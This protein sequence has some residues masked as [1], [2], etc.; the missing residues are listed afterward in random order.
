MQNQIPVITG[1]RTFDIEVVGESFYTNHF[2]TICGPR[3][4]G[5]E[6]LEKTAQLTL[7]TNNKFDKLAVKVTIDGLA[8]GHLPRDIARE[9]R[10]AIKS[11][12]LS[13]FHVFECTAWITCG[14][15]KG[16]GNQGHYCLKV[17]L[18]Q[19]DRNG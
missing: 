13:Q 18:P 19:D 10:S 3:K 17:D 8:V 2:E 16:P 12:N 15:D 5:G 1:P 7:E 9:F 14:W 4:P 6:N 11:A